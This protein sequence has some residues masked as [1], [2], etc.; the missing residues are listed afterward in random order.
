MD[1][2][3]KITLLDV[4][5]KV[6]II[7]SE[8]KDHGEAEIS[9]FAILLGGHYY[10]FGDKKI[11]RYW[12]NQNNKEDILH[13][14]VNPITGLQNADIIVSCRSFPDNINIRYNSIRPILESKKI[15]ELVM[16]TCYGDKFEGK[17][18]EYPQ[19]SVSKI[20]NNTLENK[21][22]DKRLKMTEK[23]YT[24]D[25]VSPLNTEK[26][27][28]TPEKLP[29]FQFGDEKY[30]RVVARLC[31]DPTTLSN[32]EIV[33]NGDPVWVKVSPI[34]WIVSSKCQVLL[35]KNCLVSGIKYYE[36]YGKFKNRWHGD[37]EETQV[38]QYLQDYLQKDIVPSKTASMT[39]DEKKEYNTL[40]S[41]MSEKKKMELNEKKLLLAKKKM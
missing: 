14:I 15:Y 28:F 29:E 10:L 34:T 9:D 21:Y 31:Y 38:Y 23:E 16:N 7:W 41:I 22:R 8:L 24:V 6:N 39:Y 18:G 2:D 5:Q 13:A 27:P 30:L 11:G 4:S 3:K 35:A 40:Q 37:F 17:Y 25:S 36:D 33:H 19:S 26:V 20:L 1:E 12:I 32:G